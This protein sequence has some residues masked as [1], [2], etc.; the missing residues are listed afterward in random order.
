M[1]FETLLAAPQYSLP[2][3]DKDRQL[4]L[5]LNTLTER[6]NER[7][8][9]YARILRATEADAAASRIEDVPFLPVGLFKSHILR[10]IPPEQVF[11]T[12]TSS[13][14]TGQQVSQIF[15]DKETA[16]RQTAALGQIISH[17]IGRERLP[18]VL[19]DT[20]SLLKDR[21]R[22]SARAAG[23]LGMM[24]FGRQHFY[25]LDE[26]MRLDLDGLRSFLAKFG[27]KPFLLFGFTF[28]VW[29]Y[30][31]AQIA[32]LGIDL[33]NGILVHS[34]GWKKLQ[35]QAISN[36]AFK[37]RLAHS[38]GLRR[39]FNFYGMVE[40]IG[41]IYVE[42]EDGYLYPPNF[43]D[44]IVR[45]PVTFLPAPVGQQGVIEVVSILPLSYP[46]H[47]ILTEDLGVIHGVDDSTCGRLGKRFSVIGRAPKTEL[48][49][50]SDVQA[51]QHETL[52]ET[53]S[54]VA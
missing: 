25:A 26:E 18:M 5:D 40:Q 37:T 28:M 8:P 6:H 49:G 47:A 16:Q 10:S 27:D 2:Q 52:H 43:A 45:D 4:L 22:F 23:V 13:G 15:L 50:C 46:G 20:S 3:A 51:V 31:Y 30:F 24:N 53:R 34:G 19:I 39:I 35:D 48:R 38:T 42:G 12:L 33:S 14:T 21:R 44:V 11:K 32:D 41:S 17:L 54:R 1:S 36:E 29:Q 9:E 7:C